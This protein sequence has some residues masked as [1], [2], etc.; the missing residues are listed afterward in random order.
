MMKYLVK[1]ATV[2]DPHGKLH[3]QQVDI[4][5]ENGIINKIGT[6]I[7][8]SEA[9]EISH[10]N[11]HV[12]RGWF[13][14]SVSFGEPGLEERETLANGL[15][16]AER[17]GFTA[18]A[19]NSD[20]LQAGAI[21]FNDYKRSVRHPNLLKIALQYAQ[22]FD[23]LVMSYPQEDRIAGEGQVNEHNNS[24]YLGLKGIPAL[25]EELQITRD[26]YILEYIFLQENY[27]LPP[28]YRSLAQY[29]VPTPYRHMLLHLH[30]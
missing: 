25:A 2:V 7:A 13:D 12:S 26:L 16:T 21:A 18:I 5:I 8:I 3:R 15:R 20:N 14:S 9:K 10:P 19:L 27:I 23:A 29:A 11:L 24:T 22:N 30:K 17:S 6:G 1:S 28:E 4:L